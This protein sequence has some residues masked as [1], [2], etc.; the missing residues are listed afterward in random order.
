M[1]KNIGTLDR[2]IRLVAGGGFIAWALTGG[3]VWAWI[4]IVPFLTAFVRFCPAYRLFG[5]STCAKDDKCKS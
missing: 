2:V 5:G 1:K 3:P 4:G